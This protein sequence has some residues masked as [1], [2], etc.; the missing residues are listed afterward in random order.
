MI[1][2]FEHH[3]KFDRS[4]YPDSR[5][6]GSKPHL[7]SQLV[8]IS[9]FFDA[10]RTERPYRKPVEAGIIINMLRD[11][12]GKDFNPVLVDNFVASLKKVK[13]I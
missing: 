5:Q 12:A 13:A 11:G 3:M 1:V 2:A 6:D 8:S 7:V 10:L 4:G 9:D